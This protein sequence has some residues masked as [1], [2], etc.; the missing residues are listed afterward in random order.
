MT[1]DMRAVLVTGCSSGFGRSTALLFA[2]HG[3]RV[4]AG[5]RDLT[6]APPGVQAI[7]LDVANESHIAQATRLID[8]LDCLVNN[9]G[10][11]LTGPF[12]S[13]SAAQIRRQMEV[14]FVGATLLTRSLLPALARVRGRIINVSSL[15]GE[16]G[17]PMN[18]LYSASKHALEGW[19]ESLMHEIAPLG[20]QVALVE[21]G[22]FRT[23]LAPNS[24][25]GECP[26]PADGAEAQQ[27]AAYRAM[28]TRLLAAPGRSPEEVA[29]TIVRLALKKRMPLRT[30]VG[31]DA[32]FL[33]LLR[34]VLPERWALRLMGGVFQRMLQTTADRTTLNPAA[35][36]EE[37]P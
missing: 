25:W 7:E 23:N 31:A 20:V 10:Y 2:A 37:R 19:S 6:R 21:P 11:A 17:M 22:G 5:V 27:L 34:R 35:S 30:R 36:F 28:R 14:N 32:R 15:N 1:H 13:Y 33:H 8:R 9:A 18:T 3:W 4:F 29:T 16:C 24:V 26:L 12:A